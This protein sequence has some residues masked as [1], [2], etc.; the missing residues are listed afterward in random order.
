MQQREGEYRIVEN[1]IYIN[2]S[3]GIGYDVVHENNH[4]QFLRNIV[5]INAGYVDIPDH[6]GKPQYKRANVSR[7]GHWIYR[8]RFPP[9]RGKWVDEIDY[10]L[11]FNYEGGFPPVNFV[12]RKGEKPRQGESLQEWQEL[13]FDHHSVWTDPLFVDPDSGDFRVRADSP[14]LE[15]GFYNFDMDK[16]GLL[17]DFPDTWQD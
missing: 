16:F 14:A 10:N 3:Q 6:E 5:V 15:L 1:N 8:M 12:P 2:P 7:E 11:L 4:D 9:L 13:G 17:P